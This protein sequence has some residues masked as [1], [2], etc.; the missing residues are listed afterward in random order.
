LI[1]AGLLQWPIYARNFPKYYNF[2]A[3]GIT[4]GHELM[5]AV[6]E[7]GMFHYYTNISRESCSR[8]IN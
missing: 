8:H 7:I 2:G 1:T 5:H 4:I 6:D 3:L